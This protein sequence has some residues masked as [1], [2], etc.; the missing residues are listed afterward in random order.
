[1]ASLALLIYPS[2]AVAQGPTLEP[3]AADA[4]D[5]ATEL[6]CEADGDGRIDVRCVSYQHEEAEPE[7]DWHARLPEW[8]DLEAEYRARTIYINPLELNDTGVRAID[9][10]EHRLRLGASFNHGRWL[11]IHTR[12]D[13]LDGVLWGDNGEFSETPSPNAGLSIASRRPN[14]T[15]LGVG[16]GDGLDP[17]DPDSYGPQL[18]SADAISVDHIYGNVV[19]PFGLLRVGRQSAAIGANLGGHDGGR[20]NRWGA[21]SYGD[22]ADRFLFGTKL[23]EAVRMIRGGA[24]EV[25]ASMDDGVVLATWLDLYNTGDLYR[26]GDN[27]RQNGV[28]LS[29]NVADADWGGGEW[30]GLQLAAGVVHLG[31]DNFATDIWAMPIILQGTVGPFSLEANLSYLSGQT[32]EM[33]EGLS[34]LNPRPARMQELRALGARAIADLEIGPTVLTFEFDYARGD[35]DP[36]QESAITTFTFPRDLNVGLLMFERTLAYESARVAA[37]GEENLRSLEAPSFPLTEAA[38][39]GRFTNAIAIYPQ[40]LV[41]IIDNGEHLFH[42]RFGV[43]M[44]WPEAK[45]GAVDPV[46]TSLSEDG[47]EIADDA[48]NFHGGDPGSYYGTEFD[49]QLGWTFRQNFFWTVEAAALIPGSSLEDENGDAVPSFMLENR[50]EFVF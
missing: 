34:V 37:V 15:A 9:W 50:L 24:G 45:G 47:S 3:D 29:W 31:N 10:T 28:L 17:L 14:E 49:L 35:D 7:H 38:T 36:R 33:A 42:T 30:T 32:R 2:I 44:A 8:F 48:V 12:I 39:D 13:I 11:A 46:M 22:I 16:L 6:V 23:D 21:S 20:H 1:L 25:N 5:P 43:L 4:S 27:L 18:E 41:N 19:L 40:L 26:A